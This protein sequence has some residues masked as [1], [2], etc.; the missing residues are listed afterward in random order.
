VN[1]RNTWVPECYHIHGDCDR[2]FPIKYTQPTHIIKEGS[3]IMILNRA[4]E[5]SS[6]I[7]QIVAQ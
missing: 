3:H 1:W 6:C 4:K 7:E 2:M 5:I